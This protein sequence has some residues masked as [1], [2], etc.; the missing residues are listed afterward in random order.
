MIRVVYEP[1]IPY[2]HIKDEIWY[3]EINRNAN[4]YYDYL[5]HEAGRENGL[6]V[7]TYSPIILDC[8]E[9]IAEKR[10]LSIEV[11]Y[12]GKTYTNNFENIYLVHARIMQDTENLRWN[13]D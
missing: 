11:D 4:E 5:Y 3:P 12:N 13:F 10:N 7:I 6:T 2:T 8:L 1:R 9:V